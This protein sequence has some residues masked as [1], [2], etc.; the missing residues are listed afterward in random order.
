MSF[1]APVYSGHC[2]SKNGK[3]VQFEKA[4][5]VAVTAGVLVAGAVAELVGVTVAEGFGVWVIVG[6]GV[7]EGVRVGVAVFVGVGLGVRVDV[8]LGVRV[9]VAVG[10]TA[11]AVGV[12]VPGES[13][14]NAPK[15]Q[16]TVLFPSPS[17]GR[18]KPRWSIN[19]STLV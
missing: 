8:G 13:R 6:E 17:T 18:T 7:A 2:L 11:V 5:G 14:S 4:G 15:S 3:N 19:K 12:G 16:I 10:G 9:A 1:R